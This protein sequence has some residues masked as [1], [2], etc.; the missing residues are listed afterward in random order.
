MAKNMTDAEPDFIVP[1][2]ATLNEYGL[3][4]DFCG[5]LLAA[6]WQMDADFEP[7]ECCRQCGAPDD[8]EAMAEYFT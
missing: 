2:F 8:I 1:D 6:P 7:P 3:W 5:D 4:C